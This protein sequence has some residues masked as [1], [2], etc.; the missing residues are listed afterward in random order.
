[1][2][3]PKPPAIMF[4]GRV[5]RYLRALGHHLEPVLYLGKEGVSEGLAAE[6]GRALLAHELIKVK[7]QQ[8]APMDRHDAAAELAAATAATL[9]QTLG[10]TFL[11]YKRHP[12]EPKI[13]FPKV[14]AAKATTAEKAPAPAAKRRK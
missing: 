14:R 10:R 13:Q 7:V 1:M 2:T 5:L 6:T 3:N 9:V 8:E 12:K 11:L 4:P